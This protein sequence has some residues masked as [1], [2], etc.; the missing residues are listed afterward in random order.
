MLAADH[1]PAREPARRHRAHAHDGGHV[2]LFGNSFTDVLNRIVLDINDTEDQVHGRHLV[3][4]G[5]VVGTVAALGGTRLL[6]ER[7][8]D[9]L[10]ADPA[11][12]GLV[13]GAAQ[14]DELLPS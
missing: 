4:A 12:S 9:L 11:G 3:A 7:R 6:E 14:E 5:G 8:H 2:E 10:L 1:V 13:A